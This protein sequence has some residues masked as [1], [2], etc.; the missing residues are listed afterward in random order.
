MERTLRVLVVGAAGTGRS[1]LVAELSAASALLR[2]T[3]DHAAPSAADLILLTGLDLP[4]AAGVTPVEQA[5]QDSAIRQALQSAGLAWHVVYGIG[6]ERTRNALQAVA[7]VAPWVWQPAV[8]NAKAGRWQRLQAHCEKCGDA[9]CEHR[10]F[11]SRL[12]QDGP[13]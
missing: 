9:G 11:T 13:G 4:P 2:V 7:E 5:R 3:E 6:P 10:L 12:A 1:R 8:D